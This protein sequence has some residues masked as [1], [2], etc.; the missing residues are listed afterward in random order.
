VHAR[1]QPRGQVIGFEVLDRFRAIIKGDDLVAASGEEAPED[2]L[3]TTRIGENDAHAN[4]AS[5]NKLLDPTLTL[6]QG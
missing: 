4:E 6:T 5:L 2:L 1:N 3:D